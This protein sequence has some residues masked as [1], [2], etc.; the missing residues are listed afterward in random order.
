M[1]MR[2]QRPTHSILVFVLAFGIAACQS[3]SPP[4][5]PVPNEPIV[6]TD[7]EIPGGDGSQA[8]DHQEDPAPLSPNDDQPPADGDTGDEGSGTSEEEP[9]P[10]PG[11]EPEDPETTDETDP[12]G[13][14]TAP[15][16]PTE[17]ANPTEPA[18]PA[19]PT[20]PTAPADPAGDAPNDPTS[21]PDSVATAPPDST[22]NDDPLTALTDELNRELARLNSLVPEML[23]LYLDLLTNLTLTLLQDTGELL[24]CTPLPFAFDADII[25]PAG[26]TLVVGP[27]TVSIPAGAL[28]HPVVIVAQSIPSLNVE[29][30]LIPHGLSFEKPVALTLSYG[31]CDGGLL[32]QSAYRIVYIDPSGQLHDVPSSDDKARKRVTGWLDHFS[33]YAIAR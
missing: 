30:G 29:I 33:R 21:D 12:S 10:E 31:H 9:V 14:P 13:E 32:G 24:A 19:D 25:G 26:G 3:D 18:D 8:G 15:A 4:T 16:D 11:D 7:P 20:E 17:P 1:R 2:P 23:D 27:H 22:S 6:Q 5:A 28:D